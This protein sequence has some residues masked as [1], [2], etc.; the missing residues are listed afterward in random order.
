[1]ATPEDHLDRLAVHQAGLSRRDA[2][3]LDLAH[4]TRKAVFRTEAA[5][6]DGN[7]ARLVLEDGALVYVKV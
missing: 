6:P 5:E 2:D 7:N 3:H 4:R 1:M